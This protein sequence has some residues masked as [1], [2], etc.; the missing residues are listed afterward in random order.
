MR[1]GCGPVCEVPVASWA[2][3]KSLERLKDLIL[4]GLDKPMLFQDKIH[5]WKSTQEWSVAGICHILGKKQTTFKVCPRRGSNTFKEHFKENNVIF[6][7][8]CCYENATFSDFLQWIK[9][10]D[11][12]AGSSQE[13]GDAD[14]TL[15]TERLSSNGKNSEEQSV[16]RPK[17]DSSQ[18]VEDHSPI[19][20]SLHLPNPLLGYPRSE[21][22]I[23]ADYKYMC[24]L[25][26]DM[27]ELQSAIDWSVFGFGGLSGK[28]STLWVGSE[29]AY[30]PCHYDTYGCNLVAQLSGIAI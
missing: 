9:M 18:L 21:Y 29:E 19:A 27:P 14:R 6:E 11:A 10:E 5:S 15:D 12:V 22:W 2:D 26:S 20:P 13:S 23:Y 16:K 28:D 3:Q 25:C 17:L 7:T 4:T 1:Q 30:T 24:Q 8:Q